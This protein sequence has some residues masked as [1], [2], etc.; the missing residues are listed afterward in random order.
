[1]GSSQILK[2]SSDQKNYLWTFSVYTSDA[3]SPREGEIAISLLLVP[4]RNSLRAT[5]KC[6]GEK[7][8]TRKRFHSSVYI[9]NSMD[10]HITVR[11][12]LDKVIKSF[13]NDLETSPSNA[14]SN[15]YHTNQRLTA[16]QSGGGGH[17]SF[18]GFGSMMECFTIDICPDL[19]LGAIAA[20]AAV[21]FVL[22]YQGI[23]MAVRRRKRSENV[24][25]DFFGR[26]QDI[27][28]I[29]KFVA[30]SYSDSILDWFSKVSRNLS[31][32]SNKWRTEITII[33]GLENCMTNLALNMTL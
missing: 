17:G 29:G 11:G 2:E 6:P 8:A 26:F 20:A 33:H 10:H 32:P 3:C 12:L 22:I 24:S 14:L 9:W 27:F 28:Y 13:S 15:F 4:F 16:A 31:S 30:K 23:T 18:S 25:E 21:A 1:M 5:V 7:K 19:L